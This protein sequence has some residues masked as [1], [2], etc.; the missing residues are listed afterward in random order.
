M[1]QLQDSQDYLWSMPADYFIGLKFLD[2]FPWHELFLL[3]AINDCEEIWN[4]AFLKKFCIKFC[5]SHAGS[6]H[7]MNFYIPYTSFNPE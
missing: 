7:D 6:Q 3:L 2:H 1:I 5:P 4:L